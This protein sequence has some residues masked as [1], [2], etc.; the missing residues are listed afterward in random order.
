ML[1]VI[2]FDFMQQFVS[3]FSSEF[4]TTPYQIYLLQM[5]IESRLKK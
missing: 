5:S 2:S 1:K 4:P 3:N